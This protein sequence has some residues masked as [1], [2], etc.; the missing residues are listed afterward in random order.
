M[1][2]SATTTR[3]A[4]STP[5]APA[6]APTGSISAADRVYYLCE[7]GDAEFHDWG[8]VHDDFHEFILVSRRAARITLL[9]A[10][11]D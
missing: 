9:V 4:A 11:D 1:S 10:A 3:A 8:G 7:L 5:K 6:T 2:S